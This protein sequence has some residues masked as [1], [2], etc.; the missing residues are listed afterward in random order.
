MSSATLGGPKRELVGVATSTFRG[1]PSPRPNVLLASIEALSGTG[2]GG[3]GG[4]VIVLVDTDQL[5][6]VADRIGGQYAERMGWAPDCYHVQASAGAR[7]ICTA[8]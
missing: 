5:K 8:L 7:E 6:A 1:A 4:C 2:G 3:F